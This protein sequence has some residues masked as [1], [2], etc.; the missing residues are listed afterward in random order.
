MATNHAREVDVRGR[1]RLRRATGR[2][3]GLRAVIRADIGA[4]VRTAALV[5]AEFG[6]ALLPGPYRVPNY[7]CDL[8]S[9]VTNKTPAGTLRSPGRPECN[10]VRE[11]LMDAGAARLG[12]DPAEIRRRN[13]IRADEMPYDC[14]TKSFGVEHGLRLRRLPRA[15]RRA[16]APA[17][18]RRARA[19]SRRR[20]NARAGSAAR[21]R[22]RRLRRED[23]A[24]GRSRPTQVEARRRRPLHRRHRRVV[25]GAG[26]RDGARPD[27]GRGARPAGRR[28]STCATPTPPPSRAASAPTAR[29]A[30]SPRATPPQL[31]AAKLIAEARHARGGAPGRAR[32]GGHATRRACCSARRPPR[33][34][35]RAGGRAA[36]W[37]PAPRSR[38]PKITYAGCA[39]AVVARRGSGD[40]RDARCGASSSAPTSDAR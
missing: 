21:H 6:A 23:R 29:A 39:C 14:G 17:R 18:L 13:L 5:P 9:V 16:A 15:L 28:A 33:H 11:R 34:A 25:D 32:G 37:P 8:W 2:I 27:P 19:P 3:V 38:C 30:R 20:R 40:G 31:A 4:Y 36:R 10:F 12:L 1:D 26:A 24:S 35:R 22:S 7:A